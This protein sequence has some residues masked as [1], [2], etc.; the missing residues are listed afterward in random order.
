MK[1]ER[2]LK[3]R[4]KLGKINYC[5]KSQQ[6]RPP[7]KRDGYQDVETRETIEGNVNGRPVRLKYRLI[8]IW[9]ERKARDEAKTRDRHIKKIRDGP[10]WIWVTSFLL[11]LVLAVLAQVDIAGKSTQFRC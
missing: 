7:E 6:S 10:F 5:S 8:Y 1:D 11:P 9:S 3:L 2:Y 4:S